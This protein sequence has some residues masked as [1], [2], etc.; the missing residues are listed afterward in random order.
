MKISPL[1]Q[2]LIL[3]FIGLIVL[4]FL[5]YQFALKPINKEIAALEVERDQRKNQGAGGR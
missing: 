1:Q 4:S 5:F 2:Y 3:G